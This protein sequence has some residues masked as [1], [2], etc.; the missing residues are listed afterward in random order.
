MDELPVGSIVV[1]V[2]SGL[3]FTALQLLATFAT[4]HLEVMERVFP[5]VNHVV[6]PD[7]T[8]LF[9]LVLLV[10]AWLVLKQRSKGRD[11]RATRCVG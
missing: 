9:T 10:P 4:L 7:T 6:T 3:Y 8:D 5:V 2:T 11:G 1:C